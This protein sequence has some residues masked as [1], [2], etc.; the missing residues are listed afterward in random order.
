MILYFN[1]YNLKKPVKI[2][3]FSFVE[4]IFENISIINIV[5]KRKNIKC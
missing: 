2:S 5:K 4:N 1:E 3:L